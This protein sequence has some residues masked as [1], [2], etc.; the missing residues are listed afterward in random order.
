MMSEKPRILFSVPTDKHIMAQT[1]FSMMEIAKHPAVDY[2]QMVGSP[3]DDMRNKICMYAVNNNYSHVLMIDSDQATPPGIVDM[4]LECDSPLA[5]GIVPMLAKN[6]IV[7]NIIVKLPEDEAQCPDDTAFMERWD[8]HGEP[9]EV[10]GAGTGCILIHADVLRA[11]P[12]PWFKFTT[13]KNKIVGEDIYFCHK[14]E[15]YGFRYKVHPRAVCSHFKMVDLL[16]IAK[17]F[18]DIPA[19]REELLEIVS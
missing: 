3:I 14:A 1:V 7:S 11:I 6:K 8:Y 17:A 15:Q 13:E 2:L 19:E 12:M 4:L 9:F 5:S 18:S 16:A 10:E